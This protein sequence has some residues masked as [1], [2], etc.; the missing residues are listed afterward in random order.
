MVET[1]TVPEILALL[2][3]LGLSA[4]GRVSYGIPRS[5][6]LE[7]LLDALDAQPVHS[8]QTKAC[9]SLTLCCD[10]YFLYE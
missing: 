1:L 4:K 10:S 9:H 2:S 8:C 7:T 6:L 5:K 3:T